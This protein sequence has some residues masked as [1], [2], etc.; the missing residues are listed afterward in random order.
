MHTYIAFLRAV[1]LAGHNSVKMKALT[2][3]FT[4]LGFS[5][6]ETYIQ[7][8]NVIFQTKTT[9]DYSEVIKK[10]ILRVTGLNITVIIRTPEQIKKT[11]SDNPFHNP[12]E[13]DLTRVAVLFLTSEPDIEMKA[14]M[15][16]YDFSPDKMA[17]SGTEIFIFCPTGFGRSKL[18][19]GFFEKKIGIECTARNWNTVNAILEIA[20]KL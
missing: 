6:V 8:G 5:N 9:D 3:I 2:T 17:I 4:D 18:N 20:E 11:I 7:S 14:K 1:N 15:S 16:D 12:D 19:T 13:Y 10:D